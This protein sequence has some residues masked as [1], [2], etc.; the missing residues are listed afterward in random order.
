[1]SKIFCLETEWMQSIHDMKSESMAKPLL[2][3][4]RTCQGVQTVFRQVA[5]RADFDYYLQHLLREA[6]RDYD[7]IY[8][9]FHGDEGKITFADKSGITLM[10][11]ATQYPHIFDGRVVLFD[12]CLTMSADEPTIRSFKRKTGAKLVLG[13]QVEVGFDTSFIFELWLLNH[14]INHPDVSSRSLRSQASK[15]MSSSVKEL[16]FVVY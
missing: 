7:I 1:M 9:C 3:F 14:L 13:Y 6:Y 12:S 15:A 2:D 16:K 8:L 5:T 10:D 4:L 11:L